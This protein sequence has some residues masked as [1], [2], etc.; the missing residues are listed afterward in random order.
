MEPAGWEFQI[1]DKSM[2][3]ILVGIPSRREA[4][5]LALKQYPN[6]RIAKSEPLTAEEVRKYSIE[7]TFRKSH[8][9]IQ[10]QD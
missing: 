10:D 4:G 6:G 1:F 5:V 7:G 3:I 9:I 8:N 2:H